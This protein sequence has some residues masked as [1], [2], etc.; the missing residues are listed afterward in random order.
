M[1]AA[2]HKQIMSHAGV[3][4]PRVKDIE[5]GRFRVYDDGRVYNVARGCFL[6]SSGA[7]GLA[8]TFPARDGNMPKKS[9]VKKLVY[10]AFVKPSG[11]TPIKH[12][13]GDTRNCRADNLYLQGD[14]VEQVIERN[15]LRFPSTE[16][17]YSVEPY[18]RYAASKSGEVYDLMTGSCLEGHEL[19]TGYVVIAPTHAGTR[20]CTNVFKHRFV[21]WCWNPTF[22]FFNPRCL[23]N[24]IDGDKANNDLSNLEE[25]TASENNS[26]AYVEDPGRVLRR[27]ESRLPSLELVH[28][29]S[30]IQT[31]SSVVEASKYFKKS[32]STILK[33]IRLGRTFDNKLLRHVFQESRD[34]AWYRILAY[35][36]QDW[37][38]VGV[39]GLA[40]LLV[41]DHGR[42]ASDD[43]TVYT[44]K[45][46]KNGNRAFT[47][48]GGT[49]FFHQALCL[50]FHGPPPSELHTVDHRNRDGFDN[51]PAN[52]R[53]DDKEGQSSNMKNCKRIVKTCC[54]TG[55]TTT[56]LTRKK[57]AR[58]TGVSET[59]LARVCE[60]GAV[61]KGCT[62]SE[63]D[64][65]VDDEPDGTPSG[66]PDLTEPVPYDRVRMIVRRGGEQYCS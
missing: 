30:V 28:G 57:A 53:W 25:V 32:A 41:S 47:Y 58:D 27:A 49:K 24:H 1:A 31:F 48:G 29:G 43:G 56:Y 17:A 38:L 23:I 35:D 12:I 36:E 4:E 9:F 26:K 51:R 63:H 6:A 21:Y 66:Y 10:D 44:G 7:K 14:V 59:H 34:E 54:E 18:P 52:L 15:K 46:R 5:D 3:M 50:A 33:T 62:W 20:K 61:C 11:Q 22:A 13:D 40:G 8:V 45:E 55:E 37:F 60:S 19:V 65:A 42:I 16:F 2:R 39:K 64:A